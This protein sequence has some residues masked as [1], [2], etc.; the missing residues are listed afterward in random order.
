MLSVNIVMAEIRTK[1]GTTFFLEIMEPDNPP[2]YNN[3]D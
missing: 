1:Y 3:N 2:P